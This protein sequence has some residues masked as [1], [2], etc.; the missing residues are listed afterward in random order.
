MLMGT[1]NAPLRNMM[2]AMKGVS[3]KLVRTLQAVADQKANTKES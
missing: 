1:M 3:S 2:Y